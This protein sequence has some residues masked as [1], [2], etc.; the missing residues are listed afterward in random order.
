MGLCSYSAFGGFLEVTFDCFRVAS[1]LLGRAY[2]SLFLT[3]LW[4]SSH[5]SST[6]VLWTQQKHTTLPETNSSPLK[7]GRAPKGNEK[8]FQPSI[9][10]G[11]LAVSFREG[12]RAPPIH[13]GYSMGI[14]KALKMWSTHKFWVPPTKVVSISTIPQ[15]AKT[16]KAGHVNFKSFLKLGP[17]KKQQVGYKMYNPPGITIISSHP[18]QRKSS[19]QKCLFWWRDIL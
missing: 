10:R 2:C 5:N 18:I 14:P 19:I 9:F 1:V 17:S 3:F 15:K 13:S 7:I 8:L 4:V 11:E 12:N 16:S 6:K